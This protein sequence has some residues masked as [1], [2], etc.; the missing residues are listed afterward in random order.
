MRWRDDGCALR[1]PFEEAGIRGPRRDLIGDP[2]LGFRRGA[3]FGYR[4]EMLRELLE[5]VGVETVR[6]E[7]FVETVLPVHREEWG[8]WDGG[9]L[10]PR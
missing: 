10:R 9:T 1:P 5:H 7:G 2:A 3:A 4:G 6:A 8:I